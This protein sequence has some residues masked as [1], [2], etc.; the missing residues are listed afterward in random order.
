MI[1]DGTM[2][3]MATLAGGYI[4]RLAG[5]YAIELLERRSG[6]AGRYWRICRR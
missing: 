4:T 5:E 3:Q 1:S 2:S 6:P